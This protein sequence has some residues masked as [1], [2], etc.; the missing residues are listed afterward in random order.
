[1]THRRR[2]PSELREQFEAEVAAGFA[3]GEAVEWTDEDWER[4]MRG[5][6][7]HPVRDESWALPPGWRAPSHGR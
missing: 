5:D 4:L 7:R 2:H 3:S 1:M 6:Y